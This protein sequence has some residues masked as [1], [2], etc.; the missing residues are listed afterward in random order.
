ML[1]MISWIIWCHQMVE[2]IIHVDTV[3]YLYTTYDCLRTKNENT[4]IRGLSNIEN[5]SHIK[6]VGQAMAVTQLRRFRQSQEVYL[7][8]LFSFSS[9]TLF[10]VFYKCFRI[11]VLLDCWCEHTLPLYSCWLSHKSLSTSRLHNIGRS[12]RKKKWLR[13]SWTKDHDCV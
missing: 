2:F 11:I 10:F 4:H 8:P 1:Y 13:I 9:F 5:P 12:K 7:S 6:L 3:I